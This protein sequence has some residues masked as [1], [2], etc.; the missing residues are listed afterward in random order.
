MEEKFLELNA[1]DLEIIDGGGWSDVFEKIS[2]VEIGKCIY[3][4]GYNFGSDSVKF[5]RI[6]YRDVSNLKKI[7]R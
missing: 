5:G 3:N 7:F 4:V 6:L 1:K 2:P